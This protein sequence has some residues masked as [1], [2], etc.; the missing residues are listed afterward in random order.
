MLAAIGVF[1]VMHYSVI[2]RTREIAICKTLGARAT[3][4]L[5]LVIRRGVHLA[6]GGIAA[7]AMLAFWL[8]KAVAEMLYGVS[9]SDPVS[10]ATAEF[11][12]GG[13]A[14]VACYAPAYR[15]SHVD[16]VRALRGAVG[17]RFASVLATE[18]FL[19]LRTI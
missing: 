3:D 10:F 12:R 4:V 11:I 17:D 19:F 18:P 8:S 1:A 14:V 6:M 13:I 5:A 15:A 16:P 2:A 7:G 9:A